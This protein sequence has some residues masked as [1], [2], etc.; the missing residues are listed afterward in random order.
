MTLHDFLVN[1]SE[2]GLTSCLTQ[3][4]LSILF[5]D[6]LIDIMN[7]LRS[8]DHKEIDQIVRSGK[9]CLNRF[10]TS[11]FGYKG[12][13]KVN[14]DWRLKLVRV[15]KDLYAFVL[16]PTNSVSVVSQRAGLAEI[17][18]PFIEDK[19][20]LTLWLDYSY[21]S[22]VFY[23]Q[24]FSKVIKDQTLIAALAAY[25]DAFNKVEYFKWID[26]Y[27]WTLGHTHPLFRLYLKAHLEYVKF[28]QAI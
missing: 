18:M 27:K 1:P 24:E 22:K 13:Y 16:D 28:R 8:T 7:V 19:N 4:K 6:D 23:L 5:M 11:R 21:F 2:L 10:I 3:E 26:E 15:S 9:L 25:D 17:A 14:E 20:Q 12:H